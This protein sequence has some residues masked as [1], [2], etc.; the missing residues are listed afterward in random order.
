VD[1]GF[2][3]DEPPGL[4]AWGV[5]GF[6]QVQPDF[7]NDPIPIRFL[8]KTTFV[9]ERCQDRGLLRRLGR[10][11]HQPHRLPHG[12]HRRRRAAADPGRAWSTPP[13]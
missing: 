7:E 10:D 8:P 11:Q 5:P 1:G 6:V 9:A 12:L 13:A 3:T 2:F 4:N